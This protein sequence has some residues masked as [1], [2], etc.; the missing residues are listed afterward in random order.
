MNKFETSTFKRE[1]RNQERVF[2]PDLVLFITCFLH[3]ALFFKGSNP[4]ECLTELCCVSMLKQSNLAPNLF[5]GVQLL[6]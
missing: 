5:E 2:S 6:L 1:I 4:V 3:I